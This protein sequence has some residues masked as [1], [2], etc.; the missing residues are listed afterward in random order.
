MVAIMATGCGTVTEVT[1]VPVEV[2][3]IEPP[4]ENTPVETEV[5]ELD[6]TVDVNQNVTVVAATAIGVQ[7]H[8]APKVGKINSA[9]NRPVKLVI[10]GSDT[11]KA[12]SSAT[13]VGAPKHG[14]RV[15]KD[16]LVN[17][18]NTDRETDLKVE[19]KFN[20][21]YSGDSTVIGATKP[22]LNVE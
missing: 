11:L 3:V 19:A 21:K 1:E 22:A 7:K 8:Q 10:A 13:V 14:F 4:P 16:T 2:E 18:A 20:H 15:G 9:T 6:L 12:H 17:L 5:R